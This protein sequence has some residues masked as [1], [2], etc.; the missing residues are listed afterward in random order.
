M[1]ISLI[2][3][4]LKYIYL[5]GVSACSLYLFYIKRID[6]FRVVIMKGIEKNGQFVYSVCVNGE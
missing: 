5:L 3:L 6:I 2:T 1:L 4:K